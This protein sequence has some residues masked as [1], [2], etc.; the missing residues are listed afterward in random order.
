ME[1]EE[2]VIR[3]EEAQAVAEESETLNEEMQAT[4]E[5][6]E[7]L[8]EE[9]QSTIEELK[10]A[11]A[12]LETFSRDAQALVET[13]EAELRHLVS[14]SAAVAVV[15]RAGSLLLTNAVFAA[16]FGREG[17]QLVLQDARGQPLPPEATP[18]Q[19][20]ARGETFRLEFGSPEQDGTD[21]WFVALGQPLLGEEAAILGSVLSIER[22]PPTPA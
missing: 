8:N 2:N 10:S 12:S 18:Q 1:S 20:A 21:R 13:R 3:T 5:E 11:N 4:N 7:T 6:M 9:Y 14:Q 22:L 19:R 16:W 17:T 15:D